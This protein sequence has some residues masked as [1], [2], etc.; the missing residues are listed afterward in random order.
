MKK[1]LLLTI[2][3]ISLILFTCGD[4]STTNIPVTPNVENEASTVRVGCEIEKI[5]SEAASFMIMAYR[6][7]TIPSP[8]CPTITHNQSAKKITVDYGNTPCISG[9]DSTRKSGKYE[10]NYYTGVSSDSIAG[11]ITF[12]N[13]QVFRST[14]VTDSFYIQFSG[15]DD[16]AGRMLPDSFT[17]NIYFDM[18]NNFNRN[19]NT[20]GNTDIMMMGTVSIGNLAVSTDDVFSLIGTGTLINVGVSFAYLTHDLTKP[21]MIY[22]N[23]KYA[24]SGLVKLTADNKDMIIDYYPNNGNCDA[25]ITVRKDNVTVTVDLS[26]KF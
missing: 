15:D 13:F 22:G 3:S 17:Y 5:C 19:N 9:L 21:L 10:I 26:S 24:R 18:N 4:D 8:S 7:Q 14:N 12:S 2:L 11:K 25:I 6:N 1:I 23:C 16:I 20:N